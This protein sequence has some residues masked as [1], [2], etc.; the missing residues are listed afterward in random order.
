MNRIFK[1]GE[2]QSGS[3]AISLTVSYFISDNR[4]VNYPHSV[5]F[6]S[7]RHI[8]NATWHQISG[9]RSYSWFSSSFLMN[10][11]SELFVR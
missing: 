6:S 3:W 7:D 5:C 2:S 9:M 1:A 4:G 10:S 11:R 8:I